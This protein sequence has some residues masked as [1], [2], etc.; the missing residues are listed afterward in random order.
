MLLGIT[1]DPLVVIIGGVT[2]FALMVFQILQGLR[3][4]K[5]KG[6]LHFK[7]HKAVAYAMLAVAVIHALTALAFFGYI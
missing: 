6:K 1:I 7:V 5:F 2:L 4:I 3:K